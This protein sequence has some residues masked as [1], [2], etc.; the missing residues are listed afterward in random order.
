MRGGLQGKEQALLSRLKGVTVSGLSWR[1]DQWTIFPF[2]LVVRR[3]EGCRARLKEFWGVADYGFTTVE[4]KLRKEGVYL[5]INTLREVSPIQKGE[6]R[7]VLPNVLNSESEICFIIGCSDTDKVWQRLKALVDEL[8]Q[9]LTALE[10]G[11]KK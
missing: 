10:A 11:V 7:V 2:R 9:K 6:D 3:K 8:L 4:A 5:P 1:A